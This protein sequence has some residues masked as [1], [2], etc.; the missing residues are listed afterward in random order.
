VF[1]GISCASGEESGDENI[2]TKEAD[3]PENGKFPEFKTPSEWMI[4]SKKIG[5]RNSKEW[6]SLS[7]YRCKTLP[8]A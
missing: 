6:D 7:L 4:P 5:K 2:G 3:I 1:C 8:Y